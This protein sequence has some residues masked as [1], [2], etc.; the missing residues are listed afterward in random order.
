MTTSDPA[1]IEDLLSAGIGEHAERALAALAR[2]SQAQPGELDRVLTVETAHDARTS[3]R[4]LR[5][6]HR[7]F[8][9]S[10]APSLLDPGSTQGD[11]R[12]TARALGEVRDLDVLGEHLLEELEALPAPLDE[13]LREDL[14]AE[15]RTR[16]LRAV[17]RLDPLRHSPR[18]ERTGRQLE[19]W[20]KAP[21]PLQE[22]HPEN[23]LMQAGDEA[24]RQLRD[25]GRD[26]AAL[27]GARRAAKRWRYAA[28]LLVPLL[29]EDAAAQ[30]AQALR[31]HEQLGQLQDTVVA[32]A[33]LRE[34]L[35]EGTLSEARR[36]AAEELLRRAEQRI[37]E[38]VAEAP[39]LL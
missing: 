39:H 18:W 25:A 37:H 21:P 16:R 1:P 26:L 28:E 29:G 8:P 23:S 3:L 13:V 4:R 9:R 2:L 24:R 38:L 15:L 36:E 30:H 32:S 5:A 11:L 14:L 12:F 22:E 35:T 7:T 10:V 19:A 31:I 17:A 34:V 6:L 20:R 33:F 27:H